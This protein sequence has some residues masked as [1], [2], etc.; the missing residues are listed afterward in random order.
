[1]VMHVWGGKGQKAFNKFV[2]LKFTVLI[3]EVVT[4]MPDETTENKEL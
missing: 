3:K 4:D 2:P 1:M